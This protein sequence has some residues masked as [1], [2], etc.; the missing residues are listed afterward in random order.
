MP[1]TF[2]MR[3][4]TRRVHG[5][6]ASAAAA[7]CAALALA[8]P[9]A[10][11]AGAAESVLLPFGGGQA[12]RVI[13]G[14]NGG[15]HQG[16]SRYALDLV[17]A[18]GGTSGAEVV[19]PVAGVVSWAQAPGT[20]HGCLAAAVRDGSYS[21]VLCH[22][23][24][25]HAYRAGE[26]VARGQTL[27]T[28]GPPGAVGNNGTAHVHLELHRGRLANNPVPF[29]GPDGLALDGTDL[30]ASGAANEHAGRAS[31]VSR[32]G[33][34]SGPRE[35]APA[36]AAAP[37]AAPPRATPSPTPTPAAQQAAAAAPASSSAS[38]A[39]VEGTGACLKVRATPSLEAGVVDC[40]PDGTE[41]RLGDG[42]EHRDA[43]TWRRIPG[44]G[45]AAMDFLRPRRAVITG[46]DSCLNVRDAPSTLGAVVTCLPEGT[47][48][49]IG[50]SAQGDLGRWLRVD[51]VVNGGAGWV[52]ADFLS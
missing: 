5:R 30:A 3:V 52:L 20:G 25:D 14:Y 33:P 11:P 41:V 32:N 12:V 43:L 36:P 44:Q 34:G 27:G 31:L 45:W 24:L 16:R 2:S 26:A 47:S 38:V 17:L 13:Q 1:G 21:V 23:L 40:L 49:A 28:V 18:G 6:W 19:S 22:I 4:G 35:A 8:M 51:Q 15:S 48:V 37:R 7:A 9:H 46:T 29:G 50:E 10:G 39:V 42:V